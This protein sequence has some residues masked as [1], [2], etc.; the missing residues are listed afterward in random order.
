[1]SATVDLWGWRVR[2]RLA[3]GQTITDVMAKMPA[4]E[5]GFGTHRN[6]IRVHPT[7]PSPTS[8]PSRPRLFKPD[9]QHL[10]EIGVSMEACS[11]R[12]PTKLTSRVSA[13]QTIKQDH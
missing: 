12:W 6:A 4:I 2:L 1:M 3:R 10:P 11:K 13:G 5:S 7:G 8:W 9:L